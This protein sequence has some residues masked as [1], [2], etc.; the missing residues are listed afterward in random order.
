MAGRG[1]DFT[2]RDVAGKESKVATVMVCIDT[3]SRSVLRAIFSMLMEDRCPCSANIRLTCR[4]RK[5]KRFS[6]Y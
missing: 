1:L 3:V 5:C 2:P 4:L 6:Y